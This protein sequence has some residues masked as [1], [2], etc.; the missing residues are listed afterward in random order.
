MGQNR[1]WKNEI[2]T[3][4]SATHS[5]K[6]WRYQE[7]HLVL[8]VFAFFWSIWCSEIKNCTA[9]SFLAESVTSVGTVVSGR[10]NVAPYRLACCWGLKLPFGGNCPGDK[11]LASV[12]V[13]AFA[14][15]SWEI[16][17]TLWSVLQHPSTGTADGPMTMSRGGVRPP[18][19]CA[20]CSAPGNWDLCLN[21]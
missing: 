1:W 21:L 3:R 15:Q 17:K 18:P 2:F 11:T 9:N 20:D 12:C 7:K 6:L 19:V 10:L 4:R 8:V 5:P 16:L 14:E 13:A